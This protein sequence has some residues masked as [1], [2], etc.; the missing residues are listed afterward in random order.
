MT[1]LARAVWGDDPPASAVQRRA[2]ADRAAPA[3]VRRASRCHRRRLPAGAPSGHRH[4]GL[5]AVRSGPPSYARRPGTDELR[6]PRRRAGLVARWRLRRAGWRRD[7]PRRGSAIGHGQ[8]RCRRARRHR[9]SRAPAAGPTPMSVAEAIVAEDPLR[10]PSWELLVR[11]LGGAGRVAD[12]MRSARRAAAALAE[13]GR[14]PGPGLRAAEAEVLEG[15]PSSTGRAPTRPSA[16]P[17]PPLTPTVGR[18]TELARTLLALDDARL[19]T[20]VGAGGVGKTRLAVDVAGARADAHARGARPRRAGS[21]R[22]R[23]PA[24]RRRSPPRSTCAHRRGGELAA[25]ADLG[26]LDALDRARQLR[27]RRST[28]SCRHRAAPMLAGSDQ[29]RLLATSREPLAIAGEHVLLARARSRP[30]APTR[31][32]SRL[33]RQ[34]A[35]AA[36]PDRAARP[37]SLIADV[38]ARLDGLPLA[39]EMAAARLRTMTL[40]EVASSIGDDL[41]V[42][43]TPR[44]DVDERHRT[45]RELLGLVGAAARRRAPRR[46]ARLLRVRRSGARPRPSGGDPH[47]P[48]GRHV[49]PASS[50][51]RWCWPRRHADG[52]RFGALE[53]V[54]SYGRER[55]RAAG[56]HDAPRRRHAEWFTRQDRRDSTP[57]VRTA[58]EAAALAPLR[59]HLRRATRRAALVDRRGP[60]DRRRAWLSRSYLPGRTRAALRGG[61]LGRRRRRAPAG[62]SSRHPA[63]AQR[64]GRRACPGWA[65]STTPSRIGDERARTRRRAPPRRSTPSRAWPTPRIYEG[66]LDESSPWSRG[67]TG[68]AVPDSATT[69]TPTSS[70]SAS[71]WHGLRRRSRRRAGHVADGPRC[72]RLRCCL[73]RVRPRA[74]RPSTAT[75][76]AALDHL[77][78]AVEI[79]SAVGDRLR[80][81]GRPAVVVVAA[82]ADRRPCRGASNASPS[83]STTSAPAVILAISSPACAT[84]SRC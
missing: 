45:L 47:G 71:P 68:A 11:A 30:P 28:P 66:R 44:R 83:C 57:L 23:L 7:G 74:R 32:R 13:V 19:V 6:A 42:L 10:E 72:P 37:T 34:R 81:G 40:A 9:R 55:L 46:V 2:G 62:R 54:R 25:L 21:R 80:D 4:E 17:R 26:S 27:A 70:S 14:T 29:L 65:G 56:R 82:G 53:T 1:T 79:A 39:L 73:V 49:S 78:R 51:D 38:V 50:I 41:D 59:R 43:A 61:V 31:R 33:F 52:V 67:G 64:A 77:D 5:L 24:W 3:G 35:A 15:T 48:A 20:I 36:A 16:R 12:A 69:S 58:D 18:S 76:R 75:R 63:G 60:G 22:R 84:W 8:G